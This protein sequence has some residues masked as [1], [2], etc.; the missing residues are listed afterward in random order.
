M[1]TP[2]RFTGILIFV[3]AVLIVV[4]LFL[5]RLSDAWTLYDGLG[6]P[7]SLAHEQERGRR[8]DQ[9]RAGSVERLRE[10]NKITWRVLSGNL[11]LFEAAARFAQMGER[12]SGR[13]CCQQSPPG[14][15]E[16]ERLCRQVISWAETTAAMERSANEAVRVRHKLE[17]ELQE[18]LKHAG[19]VDGP[20]RQQ[21]PQRSKIY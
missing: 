16:E 17:A 14:A 12:G 20:V 2:A 18:H 4:S 1:N 19:A 9:Q 13:L 10:K 21:G 3:A 11:T 5:E 7:I 15:S 8:L 6:H